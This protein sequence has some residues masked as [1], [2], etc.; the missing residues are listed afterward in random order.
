MAF[1]RAER[2]QG[3]ARIAICGPAGSGKTMSALRLAHGLAAG[4]KVAMLDTEAGS[5]ELYS[6]LHEYDYSRMDPPFDPGRYVEVIHE[7]ERGG[8]SVLIV[9]SLSHAWTGEG[10]LLDIKDRIAKGSSS[11]NSFAAWKDTTPLQQKLVDAILRSS[12]HIIAC[13]RTKTAWEIVDDERGRKKPVKLGLKPDQ[14]DGFDYEFTTVLDVSVEGHLASSYKDRSHVFDGRAPE[15]MTEGHGA[16]LRAWLDN[17][18]PAPAP[19]QT[20]QTPMQPTGP[21]AQAPAGAQDPR[22]LPPAVMVLLEEMS[23]T[24]NP[25]DL[26]AWGSAAATRVQALGHEGGAAIR[27]AYMERLALF[28]VHGSVPTSPA[29]Q[30][31]PPAAPAAVPVVTGCPQDP[32]CVSWVGG[33]CTSEGGCTHCI[34]E[35]C[36][37]DGEAD[38]GCLCPAAVRAAQAR[39]AAVASL[40]APPASPQPEKPK[41]HRRTKLEMA[42]ARAA[43]AAAKGEPVQTA[44]GG[45][46][47]AAAEVPSDVAPGIAAIH[48][49]APAISW[50]DGERNTPMRC[51]DGDQGDEYGDD[52]AHEMAAD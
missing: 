15:L 45:K 21:A 8:Y 52:P 12:I 1:Q 36:P 25:A 18:P 6:D 2:K 26:K 50:A 28:K 3:K 42:A 35:N 44:Q 40:P 29:R 51:G 5:G 34:L 17:A 37:D 4:G 20:I 32:A 14:R 16:A 10:G 30:A 31:A 23:R 24:E 49:P 48:T 13:I 47:G 7:A 11:N 9:D 43:E 33:K 22:V 19:V 38:G 46:G 27:A 39:T 41:R